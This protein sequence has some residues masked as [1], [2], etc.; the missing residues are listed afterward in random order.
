MTDQYFEQ[1]WLE[2]RMGT[3]D[4]TG[5]WGRFKRNI[6][7]GGGGM[8]GIQ[9]VGIQNKG[10]RHL[11]RNPKLIMNAALAYGPTV[12]MG[13]LIKAIV[14]VSDQLVETIGWRISEEG[15]A[16]AEKLYRGSKAE[17]IASRVKKNIRDQLVEDKILNKKQTIGEDLRKK[18]K[19]E[20]KKLEKENFFLLID[21]NLVK[22][23]DAKAKIEPA[24]KIL[25]EI[26]DKK[27][28]ESNST[29]NVIVEEQQLKAADNLLRAMAETSYYI[30]KIIGLAQVMQQIL[31]ELQKNL[32]ELNN[33]VNEVQEGLK[34]YIIET[35]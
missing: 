18:I 2:I 35:L 4:R 17:E 11:L 16:L 28:K 10:L 5:K 30:D 25:M 33:R 9:A 24:F 8:F 34:K 29:N 3:Q 32:D 20:I 7:Y 1:M 31:G 19:S 23:K 26:T 15:Q 21:R 12:L 14:M 13:S 22:M 27:E 6:W